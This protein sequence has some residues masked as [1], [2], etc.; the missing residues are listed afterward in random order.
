MDIVVV[1]DTRRTQGEAF[2][3]E[4]RGLWGHGSGEGEVKETAA[5]VRGG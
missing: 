3:I 4:M 5:D 2:G 1:V